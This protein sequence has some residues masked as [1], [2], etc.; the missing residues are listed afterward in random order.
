MT[1]HITPEYNFLNSKKDVVN[2][3]TGISKVLE[4]LSFNVNINPIADHRSESDMST[5]IMPRIT[6]LNRAI[7]DL[8]TTVSMVRSSSS[9]DNQFLKLVDSVRNLA[10][11][12]VA[13]ENL[14]SSEKIEWNQASEVK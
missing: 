10:A 8:E 3:E 13:S 6:G 7:D 5:E 2:R 9:I 12:R 4:K 14:I 1:I 11:L